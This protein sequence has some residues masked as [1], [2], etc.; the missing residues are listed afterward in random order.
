MKLIATLILTVIVFFAGAFLFFAIHIGI[1]GEE[2]N[3]R[4]RG[5]AI[6]I[7]LPYLLARWMVNANWSKLAHD[8]AVEATRVGLKA[9]GAAKRVSNSAKS[10]LDEAK[11]RENNSDNKSEYESK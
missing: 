6:L 7:I 4:V 2:P 1:T 10:I 3:Y 9:T 11:D 8:S 5:G